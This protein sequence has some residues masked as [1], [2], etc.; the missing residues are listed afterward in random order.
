[1]IGRFGEEEYMSIPRNL[2]EC[3]AANATARELWRVVKAVES[4]GAI[5]FFGIIVLGLLL[6]SVRQDFADSITREEGFYTFLSSIAVWTLVALGEYIAYHLISLFIQ[7]IAS[8]VHST[9]VSAKIALYDAFNNADCAPTHH[10]NTTSTPTNHTPTTAVKKANT[11]EYGK[12]SNA[13]AIKPQYSNDA[14]I[15]CPQ[16][17]KS[18]SASRNVC[19]NC[20][21]KFLKD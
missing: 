8:I 2:D 9:N 21:Q 4:W 17:G 18:Q 7:A 6:S 20:G 16:C 13:P 14:E 12:N 19:W 10:E 1:M 15:V 11:E 3:R 5:I